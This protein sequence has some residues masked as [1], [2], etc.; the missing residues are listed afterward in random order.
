[1]ETKTT[2]TERVAVRPGRKKKNQLPAAIVVLLGVI[3]FGVM[4]GG[5]SAGLAISWIFGIAFGIVLQKSRFCFTAAFRD[6]V[7]TGSTS[8][9]KAVIIAVAVASVGFGA[10]QYA[11]V[12]KGGTLP[13]FV[14]PVGWHVAIGALMF[15]IG[16]VISGGCASGTLMR[17]GEGF[18]MQWLSLI[19][20]VLGTLWGAHDYSWWKSIFID[21][22]SGV[23]LPSVLGWPLGIVLQLTVLGLLYIL[24]DRW[25]NR[26]KS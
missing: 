26:Q 11:A 3:L 15:G 9:T 19:F 24:A 17:V 21:G 4:L 6:P 7:L 5:K 1:M 10:I 18:M 13:G 20:F 22:T 14:S 25:G 23:H 2:V 16:M 8:L 12:T